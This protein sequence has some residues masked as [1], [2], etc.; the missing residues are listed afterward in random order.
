M[1]V[2]QSKRGKEDSGRK[3]F[4]ITVLKGS[5]LGTVVFFLL[6]LIFSRVILRFDIDSSL[7]AVFAFASAALAA[8]V[9][10]FAAV[11]PARKKGVPV[12][13]LSVLPILIVIAA[14]S[15]IASGSLGQNML[16]AAAIMLLG[17]AAGGVSAVNLR[18]KKSRR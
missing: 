18:R 4:A 17:G 13:A 15:A 10:G 1:S 2:R 16:I 6:L 11:R 12:G 7:L 3:K 9:S 14:V 5:A 8:F